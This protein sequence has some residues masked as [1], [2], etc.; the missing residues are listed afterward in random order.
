M[1]D[2]RRKAKHM[3]NTCTIVLGV[4]IAVVFGLLI[5]HDL[6]IKP[7]PRIDDAS[8]QHT[9]EH[10]VRELRT[11]INFVHYEDKTIHILICYTEKSSKLNVSQRVCVPTFFVNTSNIQ[12][13]DKAYVFS[14]K[15]QDEFEKRPH[16]GGQNNVKTT[17]PTV[18]RN[19]I[20]NLSIAQSTEAQIT[21][22]KIY[23]FIEG[24]YRL[25]WYPEFEKVETIYQHTEF[26]IPQ[27]WYY[28]RKWNS[29]KDDNYLI[30]EELRCLLVDVASYAKYVTPYNYYK[31]Y[32]Y[33]DVNVIN[34][35]GIAFRIY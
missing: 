20:L 11:R 1:P 25:F 32:T 14:S 7:L 31:K 28:T 8:V 9:T 24:T 6:N 16:Y 5:Y 13:G 22:Y 33:G 29:T 30:E 35:F 2:Y 10:P 15:I 4:V 19:L 23:Y 12:D 27:W 18:L 26:K 3:T 34:L 21:S 17:T